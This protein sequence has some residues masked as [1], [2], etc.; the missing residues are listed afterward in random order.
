MRLIYQAWQHI[1]PRMQVAAQ[2][3]AGL[4]EVAEAAEQIGM[5]TGTVRRDAA[6]LNGTGG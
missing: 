5:S 6:R 3:N 4:L 1:N 2:V